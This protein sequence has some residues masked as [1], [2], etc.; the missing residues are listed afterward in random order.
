MKTPIMSLSEYYE[1]KLLPGEREQPGIKEDAKR[2][3]GLYLRALP[4]MTAVD[5]KR[6]GDRAVELILDVIGCFVDAYDF[7]EDREHYIRQLCR[8]TSKFII[9]S[10]IIGE[11]NAIQIP[12]KH[13]KMSPDA[14]WLEIFNRTAALD[15]G[16]T[17]WRKSVFGKRR[18][19]TTGSEGSR[20]EP[21]K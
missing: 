2:L 9:L 11:T 8:A 7:E 17:K 18:K 3:L 6:Y 12:L 10:Q 4:M 13:E 16:V 5:R 19:G 21:N 1:P 15:E 20:Q 14:M